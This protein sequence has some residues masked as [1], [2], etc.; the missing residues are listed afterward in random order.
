ML[1]L[2]E[3]IIFALAVLASLFAAWKVGE[4]IIWHHCKGARKSRLEPGR[5][6]SG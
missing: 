1:T 6:A 5:Q 2:P 4:R 3:R